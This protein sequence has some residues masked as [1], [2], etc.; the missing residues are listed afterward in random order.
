MS[1]DERVMSLTLEYSFEYRE[2]IESLNLHNEL[3]YRVWILLKQINVDLALN[4][5]QSS[6][7]ELKVTVSLK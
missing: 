1:L 5:G 7:F 6:V 2:H 3:S 4:T